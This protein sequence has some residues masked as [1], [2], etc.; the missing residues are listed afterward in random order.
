MPNAR[1]YVRHTHL[2][3]EESNTLEFKGHRDFCVDDLKQSNRDD[4]NRPTRQQ[5]SKHVCGMLN[6]G[7]GGSIHC[8]VLDDGRVEGFMLSEY[9]KDH[10]VLNVQV[11]K[12]HL[13]LN[14][15]KINYYLII[16]L[17]QSKHVANYRTHF[18]DSNHH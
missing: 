10:F 13:Y 7:R 15:I 12:L 2:P 4:C 5:I 1:Y 8:G 18:Q 16:T 11:L 3:L 9:Q 17:Y 14:Q 6:T